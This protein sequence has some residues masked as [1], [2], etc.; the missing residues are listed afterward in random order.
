LEKSVTNGDIT[1]ETKLS[2]DQ[3][4][5]LFKETS[6]FS[7]DMLQDNTG[8]SALNGLED[9]YSVEEYE[10]YFSDEDQYHGT[11]DDFWDEEDGEYEKSIIKKKRKGA[12]RSKSELI[13]VTDEDG[14]IHS[15]LKR[16]NRIVDPDEPHFTKI[17]PLPLPI[18]WAKIIRP[19][20]ISSPPS[21]EGY[22]EENILDLNLGS[23]FKG[24]EILAILMD[25]P[26]ELANS[27]KKN[28][29]ISPSQFAKLQLG[30]YMTKGFVFIWVEKEVI[31][32]VVKI[33]SQWGFLYVENLVWVKQ[34]VNNQPMRQE[35]KYFSKSK[36]SLLFF[37]KSGADGIELRHQRNPDVVFDFIR[38]DKL[39]TEDK[40]EFVYH[41]IETLL[42]TANY[43]QETG[44]GK[45]LE[46]WAKSGTSRKGWFSIAQRSTSC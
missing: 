17:P 46:L 6:T 30:N 5:E 9:E 22:L 25:P 35:Y 31:A 8:V 15:V 42:P 21:Q 36:H 38:N 24:R 43:D 34:S 37:R 16:K 12:D 2:E 26:W 44:K 13:D 19:F 28:G 27:P 40:P 1:S 3:L 7:V 4:E 33:M 41:V 23:I 10:A 32:K 20:S 18:S 29:Q 39:L 45:F 14:Y 11:I